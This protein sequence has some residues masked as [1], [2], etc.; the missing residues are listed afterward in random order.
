MLHLLRVT[1][2]LTGSFWAGPIIRLAWFLVRGL[3]PA[4]SPVMSHLRQMASRVTA[5][6]PPTPELNRLQARLGR[7]QAATA[8][9][10]VLA[11]M[12][13]ALALARYVP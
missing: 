7:G 4:G 13:M 12:A 9:L 3:G 2:I 1:H 6:A 5:G 11:T 8:V 10:V